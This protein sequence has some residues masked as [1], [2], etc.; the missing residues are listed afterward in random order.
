MFW[1]PVIFLIIWMVE[2]ANQTLLLFDFVHLFSWKIRD[3]KFLS[4]LLKN[5]FRLTFIQLII[6]VYRYVL[7]KK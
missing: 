4:I 5:K 3:L 7:T 2:N 1:K 6:S